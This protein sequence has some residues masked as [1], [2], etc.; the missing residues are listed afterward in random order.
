MF[1][2]KC[3]GK[4][5]EFPVKKKGIKMYCLKTNSC[6]DSAHFLKGYEGKCANIHGHRWD[7][8]IEVYSENL[9]EHG[10]T[11][12]MIVDFSKLKSDL[13][14]LTENLD[15]CLIIEKN[16]LKPTTKQALLDENFKIVEVDFRPTAENFSKYFFDEMSS[17]GYKVKC[18][19]VYETPNNCAS[20]GE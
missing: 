10:N 17:M 20:Y 13:R 12:G 19:T 1:Y 16:S 18:A 5:F 7:V 11:R 9:E 4:F 8:C 14:H 6:F 15:H 2:K 3:V